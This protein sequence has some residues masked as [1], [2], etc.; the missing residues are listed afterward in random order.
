MSL[1]TL[2]RPRPRGSIRWR[3][4]SAFSRA[5]RSRGR[6]STPRKPWQ[7][8]S[9]T[10]ATFGTKTPTPSS[11]ASPRS[12]AHNCTIRRSSIA[13]WLGDPG[14][15]IGAHHRL[16]HTAKG[17]ERVHMRADPIE[18]P[19]RPARLCIGVIRG[20]ERGDENV[21]HAH[22]PALCI[23]YRDRDAGKIDEQ[24]LAGHVRLPHRRRYPPPPFAVKVAEP[25]VAVTV[26]IARAVL[27]P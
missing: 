18:D 24:L 23:K 3:S 22:L 11:G 17:S 2:R 13:R 10:S 5:K 20:A 7:K 9:A 4:G 25:A 6:A 14:L 26:L 19:L 8:P 12:K 16:R 21:R 15:K 1:F 27:L